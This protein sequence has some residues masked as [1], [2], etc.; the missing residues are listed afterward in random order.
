[1][2]SPVPAI[3]PFYFER[4]IGSHWHASSCAAVDVE[5]RQARAEKTLLARLSYFDTSCFPA[6]GSLALGFDKV[7]GAPDHQR[8]NCCVTKKKICISR[9]YVYL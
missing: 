4:S 5:S 6:Q 3:G 1:M 8:H 7:G 2:W 9:V